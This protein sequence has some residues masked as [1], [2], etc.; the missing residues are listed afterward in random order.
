MFW[1]S[2]VPVELRAAEVTACS[3]WTARSLAI[4]KQNI[5]EQLCYYMNLYEHH[6]TTMRVLVM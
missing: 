6:C 3:T 5:T 1:S 4:G 2:K